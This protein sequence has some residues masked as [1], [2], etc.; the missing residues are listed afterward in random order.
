MISESEVV[1]LHSKAI[2]GLCEEFSA[3]GYEILSQVELG[4]LQS[5]SESPIPLM[6]IGA[7]VASS[8]P[9]PKV[10]VEE[11]AKAMWEVTDKQ[12]RTV[13]QRD[14]VRQYARVAMRLL[15]GGST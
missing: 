4:Q 15:R 12:D 13:M 3:Q 10:T 11:L 5:H 7:Q 14:Y 2:Y 6:P 8:P 9:A 1:R